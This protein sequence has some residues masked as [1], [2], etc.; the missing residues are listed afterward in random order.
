MP[1]SAK[2]N[3]LFLLTS[4][5]WGAAFPITKDALMLIDPYYFVGLRFF[6]AALIL[7]PFAFNEFKEAGW[8]LLKVGL[9]LGVLN[10]S[11]YTLQTIG[12]QHMSSTRCAFITGTNVVLVP[13]FSYLFHIEPLKKIEMIAVILCFIGLYVLTGSDLNTFTLGDIFVFLSANLI[14]ISI[15]YLQRVSQ[16][17][18]LHKLLAFYQILF[19]IPLPIIAYSFNTPSKSQFNISTVISVCFC[20]VFATIL[21][22]FWQGKYQRYTTAAHTA[23]FFSLEPVF[24]CIF[25]YVFYNERLT[26]NMAMGCVLVLLSTILSV[27]FFIAPLSL[28]YQNR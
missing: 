1:S 16:S 2:A 4:V 14:A 26:T 12:M 25:S 22:L 11:A 3:L 27:V 15:V 17:Q 6:M 21:P 18:H 23:L 19:T 20:A 9:I 13:I 5:L 8:T 28:K 24:A 7:F 10:S